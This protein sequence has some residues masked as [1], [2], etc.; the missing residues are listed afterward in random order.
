VFNQRGVPPRLHDLRHSFAVAV[1]QRSY[2]AGHEPQATLPRLA[3]Y[4]G[5][6]DF[7][8]THHYLKFTEPL[9]HAANER[10]RRLLSHILIS[11]D[12]HGEPPKG[13]THE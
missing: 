5:H 2:K 8:L 9:R 3:R 4:M 12:H 7:R 11:P 13:P 1:L 10:F 6:V